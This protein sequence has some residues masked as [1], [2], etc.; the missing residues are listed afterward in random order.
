[1]TVAS[2]TFG[3]GAEFVRLVD[4]KQ[5][6]AEAAGNML[7]AIGLQG[8]A[9]DGFTKK[10]SPFPRERKTPTIINIRGT[11]VGECSEVARRFGA[12][13]GVGASRASE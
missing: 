12:L 4:V 9:V 5:I 1:M 13:G 10:H 2:G 11:T 6:G 3:Y 8:L 7:N